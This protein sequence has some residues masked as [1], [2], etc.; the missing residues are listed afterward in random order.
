MNYH[1]STKNIKTTITNIVNHVVST[2]SIKKPTKKMVSSA[3]REKSIKIIKP[4][5]V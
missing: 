3:E 5:S 1:N 4:F 2:T